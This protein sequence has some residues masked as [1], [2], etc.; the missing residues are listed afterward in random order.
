MKKSKKAA[1]QGQPALKIAI[2]GTSSTS[3]N[4]APWQDKS[5]Q[6]WSL[7]ANSARASRFD[8]WFELHT[9]DVLRAAKAYEQRLEFLKNAGKK[10]VVGHHWPE[11]PE[12]N[13]YPW[14]E[15]I[16][17]FGRYLTSSLSEMIALAIH[18]GA[19]EI[20]LWGVDMVCPDEYAHQRASCEYL[21]GIATGMGI[22]VTIAKESPILRP[23]RVYGLEDAGFSREIIERKSE[24]IKQ[25]QET[26][27][28]LSQSERDSIFIQ[29]VISVLSDLETRWA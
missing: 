8:L 1:P 22:K 14:Q 26:K 20:G 7:G 13:M 23:T 12:A 17:K 6:I 18:F 10:L 16:A 21:L 29:G 28:T 3:V 9:Q 11:L 27:A 5:W 24:A 19:T 15:I 4:E 25:L 2:V